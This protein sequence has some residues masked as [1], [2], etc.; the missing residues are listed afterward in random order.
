[1]LAD[2][3]EPLTVNAIVLLCR[4]LSTANLL[5]TSLTT[6][7]PAHLSNERTEWEEFFVH[8]IIDLIMPVF[9]RSYNPQ[10]TPINYCTAILRY[11][12]CCLVDQLVTNLPISQWEGL[13]AMVT[14]CSLYPEQ[15]TAYKLATR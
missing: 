6:M 4:G 8:T 10:T 5:H 13:V 11:H 9:L 12:I 14:G 15:L 2:S 1:M 7:S 3:L